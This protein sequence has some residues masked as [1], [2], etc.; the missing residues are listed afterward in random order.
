MGMGMGIPAKHANDNFMT[1]TEETST[2][3]IAD[4]EWDPGETVQADAFSEMLGDIDE[5]VVTDVSDYETVD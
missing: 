5:T 3:A 2:P 1:L 4:M